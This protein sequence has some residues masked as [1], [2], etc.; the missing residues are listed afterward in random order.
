MSPT[1]RRPSQRSRA[2]IVIAVSA[3]SLLLACL[4]AP[5][6]DGSEFVVKMSDDVNHIS[7]PLLLDGTYEIRILDLSGDLKPDTWEVY[8][9]GSLRYRRHAALGWGQPKTAEFYDESGRLAFEQVTKS[10]SRSY[11]D[12]EGR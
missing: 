8:V 7:H 3:T 1:L 2:A 5:A 11:D 6:F 10:G 9:D 12:D 4:A